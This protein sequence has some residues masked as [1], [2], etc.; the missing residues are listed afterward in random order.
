MAIDSGD[1]SESKEIKVKDTWRELRE[2]K[3]Q[4]ED[5]SK[6]KFGK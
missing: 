2:G 6:G 4:F 5:G 1:A 3:F